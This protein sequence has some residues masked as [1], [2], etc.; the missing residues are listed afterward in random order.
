LASTATR[1]PTYSARSASHSN[2]TYEAHAARG[3]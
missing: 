2:I 3:P 1:S